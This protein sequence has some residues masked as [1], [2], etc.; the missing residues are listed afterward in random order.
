MDADG[1][2]QAY[3]P[4]AHYSALSVVVCRVQH[5]L[6]WFLIQMNYCRCVVEHLTI[7]Q[8][9]VIIRIV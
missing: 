9:F 6:D 1:A 2:M 4:S 3:A 5:D 7:G 8:K